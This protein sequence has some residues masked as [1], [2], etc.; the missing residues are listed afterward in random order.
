MST[1]DVP[2]HKPYNK[3]ELAM[4]CWSE[5]L[6][7]SLIFVESTEGG[8]VIYVVFDMSVTPIVEYRDSMAEKAFKK[9]YSWD[10]K[11]KTIKWTWHDKTPFPWDR[12]VD[13]GARHGQGY[14]SADDLMTAAQR[15]AQSRQLHGAPVDPDDLDHL[16]STEKF[17]KVLD[18]I[19]KAIANLRP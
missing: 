9:Q 17:D 11:K 2:G 7:G 13:A 19:Q 6:D 10:G 12:V 4:G 15:V 8:K 14:A 18:T 16:T 1:N 3:D 5:H